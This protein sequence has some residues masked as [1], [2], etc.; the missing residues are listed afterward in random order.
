MYQFDVFGKEEGGL[1]NAS[2]VL[3]LGEDAK[4]R[5]LGQK[6]REHKSKPAEFILP[7]HA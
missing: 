4:I 6:L 7:V 2:R 5:N 3:D 1:K